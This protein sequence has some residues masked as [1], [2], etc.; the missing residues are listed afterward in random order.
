MGMKLIELKRLLELGE[1]SKIVCDGF[2]GAKTTR[3]DWNALEMIGLGKT[4]KPVQE[5]QSKTQKRK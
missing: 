3:Q 2:R 4:K 1:Q 5:K